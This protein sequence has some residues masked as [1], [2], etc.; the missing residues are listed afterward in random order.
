MPEISPAVD[1]FRDLSIVQLAREVAMDIQ[2]LETILKSHS[3][4]NEEWETIR[5]T[6]YFT[7]ILA[8]EAEIWQSALNT[9]ERVKIK[10]LAFVEQVL[11]ELYTRMH[12]PKEALNA[13]V[14]LI[15]TVAKLA[16][17]GGPAGMEGS[18]G[19]RLTINISLGADHQL[20]I[21]KDV[22]HTIEGTVV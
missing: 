20:K 19:E 4:S 16:G 9:S 21:E 15:K 12:D 8:S 6:P 3:L 14:E 11:P 13:K 18:V 22:M 2:D 10:S 7:K 5:V 17:L 1:I